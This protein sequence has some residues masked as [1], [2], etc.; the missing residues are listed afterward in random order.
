M[1][2]KA[3]MAKIITDI[4]KFMFLVAGMSAFFYVWCHAISK[5]MAL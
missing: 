5:W 1:T 3:K 4:I 2:I